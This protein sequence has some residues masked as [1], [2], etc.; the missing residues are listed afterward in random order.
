[1]IREYI[2][3]FSD[4]NVEFQYYESDLFRKELKINK[5][6]QNIENVNIRIKNINI[7][8]DIINNENKSSLRSGGK[9]E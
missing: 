8:I 4:I 6:N 3:F 5:V 7:K 1:V 2:S 9:N